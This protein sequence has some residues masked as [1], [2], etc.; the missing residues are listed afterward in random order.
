MSINIPWITELYINFG[1]LGVI[2]GMI[3]IGIFMGSLDRLFNSQNINIAEKSIAAG[4]ILPLFYQESNFTLMTG[5]LIPQGLAM[6]LYFV[7]SI[8]FIAFVRERLNLNKF[9]E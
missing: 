8:G 2:F 5:S 9:S 3:F 1:D 7:L 4:L 6:W